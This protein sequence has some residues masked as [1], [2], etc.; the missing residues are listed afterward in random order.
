MNGSRVIRVGCVC[1]LG[2]G[3]AAVPAFATPFT[4][5]FTGQ[6][7]PG[8]AN[9]KVPFTAVLTQGGPISGNFLFDDSLIPGP[10]TGA[11]NVFFSSIPETNDVAASTAFHLNLGGGLV[12]DLDDAFAGNAAIRYLNGAFGGFF[13]VSDFMF[14]GNP[15]RFRSE[16]GSWNI[17]LL[18]NG[19]PS[20][21]NLVNGS[22]RIGDQNLSNI[23][24]YVGDDE[25]AVPEPASLMLLG[26]GLVAAAARSRR[27]GRR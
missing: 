2:L 22:F 27:R 15:Y 5:D 14:Q 18:L 11:V 10:L 6:I 23:R 17:R 12:F 8:N 26:T 24:Q 3:L 13:F 19:N 16:G 21:T 4:A 7:S 25:A 9:V 20:G 1:L